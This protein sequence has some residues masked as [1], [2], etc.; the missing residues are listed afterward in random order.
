MRTSQAAIP[1]TGEKVHED[2][3]VFLTGSRGQ[4]GDLHRGLYSKF[5]GILQVEIRQRVSS[6]RML[7]PIF[8]EGSRRSAATSRS[9]A[10]AATRPGKMVCEYCA[11]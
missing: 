2:P 7:I 10:Q 1:S 11:S 8:G 4:S 9:P 5:T 3:G 6:V